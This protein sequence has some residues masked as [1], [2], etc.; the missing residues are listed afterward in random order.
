MNNKIKHKFFEDQF[1]L[2]SIAVL[3]IVFNWH[4][5][6]YNSTYL[7]FWCAALSIAWQKKDR[8][9]LKSNLLATIIGLILI[10]W[11]LFRGAVS[12]FQSDVITRIYPLISIAGICLLA[13]KPSKIFQYWRE[14]IIV[15]M[16]GIPW[17]HI[18]ALVPTVG[19][20][21][22]LDAKIARLMLW[23]VGFDVRRVGNLVMLPSGSIKIAGV[24]SSFDLLGL[25]WQSCIVICLYFAVA[26]N[27]KILLILCSTAIAFGVNGIR[28]CLMAVLVA[29]K[30]D[31]A[32]HYWHGSAG[33]EIFTTA[34][35]L[36]LAA[37]YWLWIKKEENILDARPT[38]S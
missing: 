21:A 27:K 6:N 18:F 11:L 9:D 26:K 16:T 25:M 5:I 35:I 14:I 31:R 1:L 38:S 10:A 2:L 32:F 8:L 30:S 7:L 24:C 22:I 20:I 36:L 29:N 17:E 13:T 23:Y 15:S 37:I 33:A 28:L 4:F 12:E 34:A 19:K 3:L